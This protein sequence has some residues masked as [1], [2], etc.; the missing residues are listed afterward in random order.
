FNRGIAIAPDFIGSRELSFQVNRDQNSSKHYDSGITMEGGRSFM[1]WA[2]ITDPG[3]NNIRR[4]EFQKSGLYWSIDTDAEDLG[5]DI[6]NA[7]LA[8]DPGGDYGVNQNDCDNRANCC[9]SPNDVYCGGSTDPFGRVFYG[10]LATIYDHSNESDLFDGYNDVGIDSLFLFCRKQDSYPDAVTDLDTYAEQDSYPILEYTITVSEDDLPIASL[11][12]YLYG[13]ASD[14]N[15]DTVYIGV[16]AKIDS[17]GIQDP[18]PPTAASAWTSATWPSH[19]NVAQI[20]ANFTPASAIDDTWDLDGDSSNGIQLRISV[21]ASKHGGLTIGL[22]E[23]GGEEDFAFA[24]NYGGADAD[25]ESRWNVITSFLETLPPESYP[26]YHSYTASTRRNIGYGYTTNTSFSHANNVRFKNPRDV[27]VYRDVFDTWTGVLDN[28]APV[29]I[30]VADTMNSRIQVFMNATGS[31]GETNAEFPIRPV[32]VRVPDDST[33]TEYRSNEVAMRI[34][35]T[36]WS[37]L[38]ASQGPAIEFGDGRKADW[39]HYSTV[40]GT[41]YANSEIPANAGRGEF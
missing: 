28:E 13:N 19:T 21:T 27:D 18:G 32:R 22:I 12:I 14:Q 33:Y 4:Y 11:P 1:Q 6:S 30:F 24:V 39:R 10:D 15:A 31:A 38:T 34:Y 20:T 23:I 17:A 26:G 36:V 2:F 5:D 8:C 3:N 37:G 9:A 16:N 25:L 29:Y 7:N 40:S 35:S 41:T